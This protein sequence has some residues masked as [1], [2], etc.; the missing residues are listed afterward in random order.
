MNKLEDIIPIIKRNMKKFKKAGV[1][2][3]R[4]GY[5]T[6][7]NWPTKKKAIVAIIDRSARSPKLPAAVEGVP[8]EARTATELEQFSYDHPEQYSELAD[9]RA[10]LRGTSMLPEF[11]PATEAF[12]SPMTARVAAAHHKKPSLNYT[13]SAPNVPLDPVSGAIRIV[14]HVSPDAGWPTLSEFVSATR[15]QLKVSMYDFTSKHILDLFSNK[16]GKKK[17]QLTLDDPPANPSEDQLDPETVASLEQSV[18]KL[19][20]AWALVRSSPEADT[21]IFPSAYH[22]KVMVR[23]SEAVWLSSGNLNNSN[24]PEMDPFGDPKPT[25][26]ATAKT[27][28]RDWHVIVNSPDLARTLEAYL[29]SDFQVATLHAANLSPVLKPRRPAL[30]RPTVKGEFTFNAPRELNEDMT[31]TPLLTPDPGVYQAAMLELIQS[32]KKSILVQLQYIHPTSDA[33][34]SKFTDLIDALAAKIDGGQVEV[35]IILS[36]FQRL[37]GGLEALQA[38]GIHLDNV[39]VQNNVHNKGFVFDHKK[40]VVSSMNWSGEGILSNRDAGLII[41]NAKAAAYFEKIFRDDWKIHAT[42]SMLP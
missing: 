15:T 7:N 5:C 11:D 29:D 20:F 26:Q 25:D 17:V 27:S 42:Q 40:V 41:D 18:Q 28:D 22:I 23:D 14:C 9:H 31:I 21:W 32:A 37:K 39:K 33:T 8:V 35:K 19:G 16:L 30:R 3:V 2:Y 10:E 12:R 1:L 13:A 4:P 24:Q 6:K 36:E 34:K 38:A